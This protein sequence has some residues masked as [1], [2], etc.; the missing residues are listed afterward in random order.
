MLGIPV[1]RGAIYYATTRQREEIE[2]DESLRRQTVEVIEKTRAML[3]S[4]VLPAAFNDKRCR[5]CSLLNS[6]LPSVTANPNRLRGFQGALFQP[7][8]TLEEVTN[9]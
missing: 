2:I 5:N 6:C 1:P 7:Y 9:E 4:Q 8:G 3:I